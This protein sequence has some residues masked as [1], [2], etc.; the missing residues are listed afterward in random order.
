MT[1]LKSCPFCGGEEIDCHN[2]C[3]G[4]DVWFVQ[5]ANC[6]ATFPH[7]DSKEEAIEAWN[8]RKE[9][10]TPNGAYVPAG[11]ERLRK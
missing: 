7:F 9:P 8:T 10:R 1:K 4:G 11:N 5:C 6:Y 2:Y 3:R